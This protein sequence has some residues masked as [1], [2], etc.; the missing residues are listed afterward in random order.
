MRL[1]LSLCTA[2]KVYRRCC[3]WF[4]SASHSE[5]FRMCWKA[6]RT[7][8][9]TASQGCS[10]QS[11]QNIHHW[12]QGYLFEWECCFL[13]LVDDFPFS[14]PST[15]FNFARH[16][17]RRSCKAINFSTAC[18]RT[19]WFLSC[20]ASNTL[21]P[22]RLL[23]LTSSTKFLS[24]SLE[25]SVSNI[26]SGVLESWFRPVHGRFEEKA[27]RRTRFNAVR[28]NNACCLWTTSFFSWSSLP[29]LESFSDSRET[30]RFIFSYSEHAAC[31]RPQL[32]VC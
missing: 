32:R 23:D 26:D 24:R 12:V 31:W 19:R 11:H 21:C 4:P 28:S 10:A 13:L 14:I 22:A 2:A 29:I 5:L 8:R 25:F 17:F 6:I 20:F 27:A 1:L 18:T 15:R 9:W 16:A 7:F 3:P 30:S